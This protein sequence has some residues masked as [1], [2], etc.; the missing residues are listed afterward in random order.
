M[1]EQ[2]TSKNNFVLECLR[3]VRSLIEQ[4]SFSFKEII[5]ITAIFGLM[6]ESLTDFTKLNDQKKYDKIKTVY[7][8]TI[9][10]QKSLKKQCDLQNGIDNDS[11]QIPD[12]NNI[13]ESKNR[14]YD[15]E[16]FENMKRSKR[17]KA[18]Y[19]KEIIFTCK[20]VILKIMK[21]I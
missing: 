1:I 17:F 21:I 5:D 12:I 18:N 2:E 11:R 13:V 8:Q 7:L 14:Q 6:L 10:K 20:N 19:N 3:C 15:L 16:F 9:K 4:G